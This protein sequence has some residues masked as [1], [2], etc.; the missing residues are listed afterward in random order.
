MKVN[1]LVKD[2]LTSEIGI[3]CVRHRFTI[4]VKY[5]NRY[6]YY[7]IFSNS[8]EVFDFNFKLQIEYLKEAKEYYL[9]EIANKANIVAGL[10]NVLRNILNKHNIWSKLS[11]FLFFN[12]ENAV[13]QANAS[14]D[15]YWWPISDCES[16]I[17][18]IDYMI[19]MSESINDEPFS[20][21]KQIEIIE[22]VIL[23]YDYDNSGICSCI[24]QYVEDRYGEY[25][26]KNMA[27]K[28]PLFT[29]KNALI[30]GHARIILRKH[31]KKY[32]WSEHTCKNR[33]KFLQWMLKELKK[34]QN[35]I[36]RNYI[37]I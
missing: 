3:I 35:G 2:T 37:S 6:G 14:F 23:N 12:H 7:S 10:C 29:Y 31:N 26:F 16:R 32:W 34:Q 24:K 19:K 22:D 36:K 13:S 11:V 15:T 8:L 18:F 33:L 17:K 20:I 1:D 27:T 5:I 30:H 4:K 28:F 25:I 9:N 21:E